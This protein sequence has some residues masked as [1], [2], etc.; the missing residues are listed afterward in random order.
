MSASCFHCGLPVPADAVFPIRY[1]Q[2]DQ[3]AC[4]AGCQA[5]AQTIIDSGLDDYYQH[6]T[7]GATQAEPLPAEL[8]EQIKLYDAPELQASFVHADGDIREASLLLEG[9]TCAACVWLNERHLLRQPGVLSVDVNYSSLRARVRWDD[10]KIRLSQILEAIAAIGYRAHPYDAERQEKLAQAERKQQMTRL[11]VAGLSMMQVMMYVVPIYMFPEGDIDAEWLWLLHWTSFI[12]TLPVMLYSAVPFYRGSWRDLKA[13]RAGMDVP[14]TLG[15]LTAFGASSWALVNKIEHGIYFDSVSMFVFLLLGGR[16]LEGIARRRAG[17]AAERLVKLIPAFTQRVAGWPASRDAQA[18]TVASVQAGDVLLIK[19]GDT[20]PADG[21]VLD[22]RTSVNESLLTGESQPIAKAAGDTVIAGTVNLASPVFMRVTQTGEQTKLASI[23]RL[24]D[25]ALAEKPRLAVLADRFA[26][27]FV[28]ILLLVA[29]ATFI[30]WYQ[31]DPDRALW[32]TV[33]VLVI[34]CPCALSLATPAALTAAGGNLASRGVLLA[35]GQAL[36]TLAQVSDAVFDK[37]GTLTYG[38][39]R[40]LDTRL[41]APAAGRETGSGDGVALLSRATAMLGTQQVLALAAGLEAGSEHP[42]AKALLAAAEG[43]APVDFDRI[44]NTAGA[45]V[46]GMLAGTRYRLG[47]PDF[48]AALSGPAPAALA[49][50]G[51]DHTVVALGDESGW[52]ALFALGDELRPDAAR[53]IAALRARGI[54]THLASG[55]RAE[56]AMAA[57]Q[58]L[59]LDQARGGMSPQDKLDYVAALQSDGRRVLMVGDGVNDA[60]VL[61][62]ADVSV[63]MGSGTDVARLSGDMVLV[64]GHLL[65]LADALDVA[66]KTRAIIRE[67]LGWAAG[68]N[69]I[70][71]PLAIAGLVTPWIASLGMALSSLLVVCNALRLVRRDKLG[72]KQ[73]G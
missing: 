61:A 36:E 58:K 4:C 38:D 31:L 42:I 64:D 34:S 65:T 62:R 54:R 68:Y 26:A 45:G 17:D 23:V 19:P 60:P 13:G 53:L 72:G 7:E 66:K 15:I 22:G 47:K 9:I 35:R 44:A 3:P 41:L 63:A 49:G 24:L 43:S 55:D 39:M 20:L 50:F 30:G 16:F 6:R 10:S 27:W 11:W 2:S 40:V 73:T 25:R 46:E 28:A 67:N 29:A 48:I 51:G 57:G 1:R 56:A 8:L 37:T 70:A 32:V 71:L 12:L 14:V 21:E 33:A 69:L 5:V 52:L 59:G 18:A